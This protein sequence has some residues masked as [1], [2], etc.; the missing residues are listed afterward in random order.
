MK[1]I[2]IVED[3]QFLNDIYR[4]RFNSYK[5]IKIEIARDGNEAFDIITK[6]K[7]DAIILDLVMPNLDGYGF[8]QKLKDANITVPILVSSN[9][10]S[11]D[12]IK[13]AIDLGAK[14]Y[15]IKSDSTVKDI[16]DK[17][18]SIMR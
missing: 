18:M 15:F 11:Q 1:N 5:N 14:D 10:D 12:D 3:D 17:I 4:A 6:A 16:V 8:L 7:P 13:R 2:L 9:L